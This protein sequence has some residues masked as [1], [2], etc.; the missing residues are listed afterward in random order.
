MTNEQLVEMTNTVKAIDQ[1]ITTLLETICE[2]REKI[3][4]LKLDKARLTAQVQF[5]EQ[6][7]REQRERAL[8]VREVDKLTPFY[9]EWRES[10]DKIF[11]PR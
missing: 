7:W 9:A 11:Q 10:F 3:D 6:L 1:R 2:Q 4:Q 8:A 5:M